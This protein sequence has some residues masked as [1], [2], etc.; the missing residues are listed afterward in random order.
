MVTDA[1][2]RQKHLLTTMA[3]IVPGFEQIKQEYSDDK[4]FGTIYSD[5]L[6]GEQDKHLHY[7]IH[8][9]LPFRGNKLCLLANSIREHV[10]CELHLGGCS[11]HL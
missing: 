4:D 6:N 1:L 8:D 7:N 3:V 11:G 2:S 5:L 10:V 9:G